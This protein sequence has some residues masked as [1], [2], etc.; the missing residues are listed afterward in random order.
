[1][2][3]V[4]SSL[5]ESLSVIVRKFS[6]CSNP[7]HSLNGLNWECSVRSLTRKHNCISSIKH[8]I[9]N[10]TC[11]CS[12]RSRILNHAFHHLSSSNY[13]FALFKCLSDHPF[14]CYKH[15][16]W[17]NFHT[18]IS[19][20]NHDTISCFE[21][22]LVVM[23]T[24]LVL[25]LSNDLNVFALRS[26]DISNMLDI[27]SFSSERKSNH[28]NTVL[29]TEIHNVVFVFVSHGWKINKASRKIHVFLFTNRHSVLDSDD[30]R[31]LKIINCLLI[32]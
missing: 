23:Q 22:L 1:M 15:L 24:L 20:S 32:F 8:S 7:C 9:S 5:P 27:F 19:S 18:K 25:D 2:F 31:F 26:K 13:W 17:R 28:V 12:S 4:V 14:L 3:L 21:N 11:L 16:L 29:Q 30:N 10:I 6:F